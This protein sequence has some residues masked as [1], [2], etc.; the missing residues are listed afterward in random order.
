MSDDGGD[1][2]RV[3]DPQHKAVPNS[4]YSFAFDPQATSRVFVAAAK[5]HDYPHG[6]YAN[7][8]NGA[9]GI[10]VSEDHGRSFSRVG[11]PSSSSCEACGDMVNDFLAV[12]YD[13]AG[14]YLYGGHINGV[15]RIRLGVD[16]RWQWVNINLLG[17]DLYQ[18][19]T[20][21]PRI[22]IDPDNGDVY[23]LLTGNRA[24][25]M[26]RNMLNQPRTGIYRMSRGG[27]AWQLLR[28]SVAGNPATP[29][30]KPWQH[31]TSFAVDWSS[32]SPG[33][34]SRL[35][36]ADFINNGQTPGSAG[37]FKTSDGGRSWFF[38]QQSDWA[39][40]VAY[41]P[42]HPSRAYLAGSRAVDPWGIAQPGGWG[43][44]GFMYS[45][46]GGDSWALADQHPFHNTINSVTVDPADP[47][48]LYYATGGAGVLHG[49]APPGLPGC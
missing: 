4:A 17:D 2:W 18:N 16:S 14:G 19:E 8:L 10:F 9:G 11:G 30:V 22:K 37:V 35:L 12:E 47:C 6:W 48:K 41:D 7:P 15:A 42:K 38:K 1:T 36:L 28:G 46:D 43:Y 32:G 31:P 21:V 5:W 39:T 40:D 27:S 49:A 13:A 26:P 29:D 45:D 20:I 44:G 24:Y 3:I 34:R 25:G 33:N 23:I